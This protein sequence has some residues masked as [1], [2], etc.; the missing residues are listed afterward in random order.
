MCTKNAI[1]IIP[2]YVL[3]LNAIIILCIIIKM[4]INRQIV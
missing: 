4:N 1:Q 2:I 3:K